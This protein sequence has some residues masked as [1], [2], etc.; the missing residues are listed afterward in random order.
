MGTERSTMLPYPPGRGAE[1]KRETQS[2]K[3]ISQQQ[4]KLGWT[5]PLYTVAALYI[6]RP[7]LIILGTFSQKLSSLSS[8]LNPLVYFVPDS[9]DALY[10]A[11]III[12]TISLFIYSQRGINSIFFNSMVQ[13]SA[14]QNI[15][16]PSATNENSILY[17]SRK[18]KN[19]TVIHTWCCHKL[20]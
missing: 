4:W 15:S 20:K 12:S 1:Y 14:E 18:F 13:F 8:L 9:L 5:S 17:F 3:R 11:I 16:S 10:I 7:E 2:Y 19:R 6:F